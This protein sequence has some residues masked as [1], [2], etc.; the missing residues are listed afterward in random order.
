MIRE[1]KKEDLPSA[2]ELVKE[3]AAY[4]RAPHEVSNTVES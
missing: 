3:L 4:E 1:G 2:L